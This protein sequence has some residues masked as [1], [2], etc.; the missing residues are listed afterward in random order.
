[1]LNQRKIRKVME[2]HRFLIFVSHQL[3]YES[4]WKNMT[5]MTMGIGYEIYTEIDALY[6]GFTI[7]FVESIENQRRY[8]KEFG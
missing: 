3:M 1:M 4:R 8:M 5:K 7:R 6:P 2:N